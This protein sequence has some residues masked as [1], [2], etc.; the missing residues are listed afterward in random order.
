MEENKKMQ[1][2]RSLDHASEL[3]EN[4]NFLTVT[5]VLACALWMVSKELKSGGN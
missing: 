2:V 1:K 4:C 3:K 5:L